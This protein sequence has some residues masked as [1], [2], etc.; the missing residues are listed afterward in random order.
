MRG[1]RYGAL[2]TGAAVVLLAAYFMWPRGQQTA[3][4]RQ[5]ETAQVTAADFYIS[6]RLTGALEPIQ[7]NPVSANVNST[8]VWALPDGSPVK[9]GDVIIKLDAA[10]LER[11][12]TDLATTV[13]SA[14]ED[15]RTA[16]ADG[17][18]AVQNARTALTKA[19]E[20]LRLVQTQN[21]ASLEKAQAETAFREK[22]LEVAQGQLDRNRRLEAERL[23]AITDVEAAEDE[24]RAAE[25]AL[26]KAK[27][28][29]ARAAQDAQTLEQLR[30]LEIQKAELEL[31]Q[32][33]AGLV[34]RV[35]QAK[36]NLELQRLELEEAQQQLADTQI[37]APV[38]GL[39]MLMRNWR[40]D[41]VKVGDEVY[42]GM[43]VAGVIVPGLVRVR[44]NISEDQVGKVKIGQAA[45]V[46]VAGVSSRPLRA[47]VTAVDNLAREGRW[48]E[49]GVPGKKFFAALIDLTDKD[50]RLRPGMGAAV[51]LQLE[52]VRGGLAVPVQALFVHQGKPVVYVEEGRR[53]RPVEV[54]PG[55][56]N[57][58]LV[59]VEGKLKAGDKVA[60]Q[61]PPLELVLAQEASR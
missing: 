46:T 52:R 10:E 23:M 14:E 2:L 29:Q 12:V 35:E 32:A 39:L 5:V 59:V 8:I 51:E 58:R 11:R 19:Q 33:E 9:A 24:V 42:E 40:G 17:G 27:R 28:A 55:K 18:R 43:R 48:W 3:M 15:V 4:A 53:Y 1:A 61:R 45:L 50:T 60:C 13:L 6:L 44:S 36:R 25:F 57:E 31:R 30:K 21:Q 41:V 26:A 56:R 38:D 49:G 37:K 47:K 22:E 34:Q 16:E 7:S 20:S 54:K